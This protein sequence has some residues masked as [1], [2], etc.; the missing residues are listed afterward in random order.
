MRKIDGWIRLLYNC[1]PTDI[2]I[3]LFYAN[4]ARLSGQD[5]GTGL[6]GGLFS[7]R[8]KNVLMIV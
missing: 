3:G 8:D 5:N 2:M 1:S 4:W 6:Y 7:T